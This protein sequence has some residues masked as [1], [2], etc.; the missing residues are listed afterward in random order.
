MPS[1]LETAI[2]AALDAVKDPVSGAGLNA[3]G[4]IAGLVVRPDGKVGFVLE[5][6]AGAADEPLRKSAEAAV[7]RVPG[8]T[9]VTA[10]LTAEA[11][12]GARSVPSS[13]ARVP[14]PPAPQPR[15][16]VTRPAR[17]IVAVASAKGGV[18]KSTVAVNL[19]VAAA[20]SGLRVGLLDAD[21]F[22]PSVPTMMGTVGKKPQLTA[23]KK[24]QPLMAH[25]V[26]TISIGYLVDPD[27]A[28]VW[29]GPMVMSAI[30]QLIND[31]D[32]GDL[33]IL[34]IDTPPGTG[35]VQLTLVQRLPLD[36]AVIVSTP[37]E[38]ALADVRRGV[39]MF[40]KTAVPVLGVIENMA[41]FEQ[42]DGSRAYIFGKE[43]AQRTAAEMGVPFLGALPIL[44][45]LREGGDAGVPAATG[46]SNAAEAF[47]LLAEAVSEALAASPNKPAP[48]IVFE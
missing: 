7:A 17:G 11:T 40:R 30:V 26:A 43:G 33:D 2:R 3:S 42:P 1:P 27:N 41:W 45:V 39:G 19:A 46:D 14:S 5:T 13:P 12:T 32:W 35:E 44:P 38:V 48:A 18:G 10:V 24:M 31:T 23:S 20:R 37:Q 4:R 34:F 16:E 36:G 8:V 29:R 21:V 6:G 47:K 25:G 9:A 22:G 28:V 15:A